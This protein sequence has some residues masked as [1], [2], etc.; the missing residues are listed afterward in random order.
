MSLSLSSSLEAVLFAAGE[1]L[2][3]KELGTLLGVPTGE[4][5]DPIEELRA[6]LQGRG[7]ALIETK[8]ELELRTS[9]DAASIVAKYREG[10]LSRDLGK[11]SLETLAIIL[12]KNGATRGEVDWIRGV[13]SSAAARALLLRG[14]IEKQE[15]P[16]DRRRVRYEVTPDALGHLGI[17]SAGEAPRYSELAAALAAEKPVEESKAD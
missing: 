10:E 4:L 15:D 1:P 14:L 3:R 2:T 6:A 5:H 12:Y 7:L 13:N 16:K 11:A 9:P 17:S 8:D